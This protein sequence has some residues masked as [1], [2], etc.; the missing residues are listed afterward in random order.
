[1]G[2]L[3]IKC[4][5]FKKDIRFEYWKPLLANSAIGINIVEQWVKDHGSSEIKYLSVI[6]LQI[7]LKDADKKAPSKDK[8]IR[9]LGGHR[10]QVHQFIK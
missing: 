5:L 7:A 9:F 8:L 6:D 1:M 10:S 4:E 3:E 2:P